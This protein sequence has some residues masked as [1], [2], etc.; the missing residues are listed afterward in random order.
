MNAP[1]K[2]ENQIAEHDPKSIKAYV[3]DAKIRQ[4]FEEVLGKKTQ[5]FL[6]SVMQVANQPQLKGAVPATVINAAMMAATLDLPINN[7]LGFAYIVPYKRK[8]K[9]AQGK[10]SESLEAQFQMG[11]KGFI[12][13][14]QRSGQFARIAAT[15]VYEGQLI[16]ANPLLGY[17]FDWTIPNQGEAIG[18]VAFFK[19][20]NGFTAELYMSTADVKKHAGKYSQSFKY[21]SGVWKD[22]FESMALK[23]VTKLLLSKQAPLS[24]E[25]QTAQLADQAIVRDVETNDFDYI[26]H[27]ESVGAIETKMTVPDAEFPVLLEQIKGGAFEKDYVLS[28][29]ALTDAQR[30]AVEVLP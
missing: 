24:I 15:P 22:N 21:G 18:Y 8:F 14:A 25:M 10:W 29:Y 2:K 28:E 16:S 11:Y 27:N 1:V 19:L 12:Q 3:S 26:D 9:D 6:A 30:Q 4:K 23:T 13:L 5:G 17:E 7:N 20:L